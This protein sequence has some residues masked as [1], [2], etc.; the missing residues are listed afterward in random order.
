MNGQPRPLQR[1]LTPVPGGASIVSLPDPGAAAGD[2][3][4]DPHDRERADQRERALA[5]TGPGTPGA[6]TFRTTVATAALFVVIRREIVYAPA[7]G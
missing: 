3:P 7:T 6:P 5:D 4:A 2:L 1:T